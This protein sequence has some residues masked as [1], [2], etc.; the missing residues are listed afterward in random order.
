MYPLPS[1]YK[2]LVRC[3]LMPLNSSKITSLVLH[4]YYNSSEIWDA[5]FLSNTAN[6]ILPFFEDLGI[7]FNMK[8]FKSSDSVPSPTL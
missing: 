6:A 1:A 7:L 5:N 2:N 8:V 3:A 4:S